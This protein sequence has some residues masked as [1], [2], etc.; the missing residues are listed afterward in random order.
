MLW[1]SAKTNLNSLNSL[2]ERNL[3]TNW[4]IY[5][6]LQLEKKVITG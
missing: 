5:L 3:T 2:G 1:V 6:F 4:L